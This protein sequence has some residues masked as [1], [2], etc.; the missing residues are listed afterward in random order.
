MKES[1]KKILVRSRLHV[2]VRG[3][4][5]MAKRSDSQ[6]VEGNREERDCDRRNALQGIWKRGSRIKNNR[7]R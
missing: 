3:D 6:K 5:Q 1:F 2:E 4:E 7:K